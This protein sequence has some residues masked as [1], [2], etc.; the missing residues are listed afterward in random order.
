MTF[1]TVAFEALPGCQSPPMLKC[2]NWCLSTRQVN[3]ANSLS[4]AV[5]DIGTALAGIAYNANFTTT[6]LESGTIVSNASLSFTVAARW[7]DRFKSTKLVRVI[8]RGDDGT[9]HVLEPSVQCAANVCTVKVFS[10]FGLSEFALVAIA[11]DICRPKVQFSA[12]VTDGLPPLSV[13]FNDES[14]E[15]PTSW[16]WDFGDG[17]PPSTEQ[18]PVHIYTKPGVYAVT[19]IATNTAGSSEMAKEETI[20]V[21]RAQTDLN[22]DGLIDNLDVQL[23]ASALGSRGD[24]TGFIETADL[25]R[26]GIIDLRDAALYSAALLIEES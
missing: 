10:P 4:Q 2:K 14:Q 7:V 20:V 9:L 3:P 22:S 1:N 25:N 17:T 6:N 23:I 13:Q 19:L 16:E 5:I 8:H 24:D 15:K 26:D 21:Q 12:Q 18:N 11:E